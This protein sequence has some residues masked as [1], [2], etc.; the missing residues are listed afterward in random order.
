MLAQYVLDPDNANVRTAAVEVLATSVISKM[1]S[2]ASYD[3]GED[4]SVLSGRC[5]DTSLGVR[6]AVLIVSISSSLT[7][8]VIDQFTFCL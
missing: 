8:S 1:K 7:H 6:L 3:P 2:P 4:F 5:F